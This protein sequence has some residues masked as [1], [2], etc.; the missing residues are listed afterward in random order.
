MSQSTVEEDQ[1]IAE[2]ILSRLFYEETTHDRIISI[3]RSYSTQDFGYLDACTELAHVHLRMLEQYS[4][5][6]V[7]MQVRSR[8][9]IRKRKKAAAT[10]RSQEKSGANDREDDQEEASER[11]EVASAQRISSERRFDFTRFA[12]RFMTQSCVDT[13]V[14]LTRFYKDLTSDQLKRAHRFFH[15]VAFKMEMSVMLFRVDI[16]AL[17]NKMIKGQDCLNPVSIEYKE[18]SELVRQ[19]F[20]R[21]IRMIEQR[22]Q[23]IVEMLFSKIGSTVP[24]LEHGHEISTA[25]AKTKAPAELQVKPGFERDRQV[26]IAVSVLID[27]NKADAVEWIEKVLSSAAD[28]RKGWEA[29]R[30]ARSLQEG[31]N[32]DANNIDRDAAVESPSIGRYYPILPQEK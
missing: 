20:K 14:S 30:E 6:N 10:A 25:S 27:Q 17:F 21:M 8:R 28:T 3:V 5:Q 32:T 31:T 2:N 29:E 9:I 1:T 7:E 13:F 26:G 24:Y 22:P 18:W 15:R 12:A 23:L 11:E 4:K 19:L 16:I